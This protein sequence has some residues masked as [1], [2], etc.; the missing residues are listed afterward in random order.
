[1][2]GQSCT[3]SLG[4]FCCILPVQH[5]Y[6]N[7]AKMQMNREKEFVLYFLIT[8]SHLLVWNEATPRKVEKEKEYREKKRVKPIQNLMNLSRNNS[9]L[10]LAELIDKTK[11]NPALLCYQSKMQ[12]ENQSFLIL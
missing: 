1:M 12:D 6:W 4:A 3:K 11:D 10:I 9:M 7:T 8:L 5:G 2:S